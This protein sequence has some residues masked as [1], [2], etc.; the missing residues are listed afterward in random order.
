LATPGY[1]FAA[2]DRALALGRGS[3]G[4]A[5]CE[6]HGKWRSHVHLL[7]LPHKALPQS[8]IGSKGEQPGGV[9]AGLVATP[10]ASLWS[11][12]ATAS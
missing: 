1:A 6:S 2:E 4:S 3:C 7:I 9:S 8:R 10:E 11:S 5:I 12:A